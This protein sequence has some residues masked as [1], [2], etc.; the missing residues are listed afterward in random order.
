MINVGINCICKKGQCF[1][2]KASL[3]AFSAMQRIG[4]RVN[5]NLKALALLGS[6]FCGVTYSIC[7]NT[8]HSKPRNIAVLLLNALLCP[9]HI[10]PP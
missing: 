10:M 6:Y 5:N 4:G 9:H 3:R 2:E 8:H 1:Y 7:C